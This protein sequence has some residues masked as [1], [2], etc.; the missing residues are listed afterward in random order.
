[1]GD[2]HLHAQLPVQLVLK[3]GTGHVW[4][5]LTGGIQPLKDWVMDFMHVSVPAILQGGFPRARKCW[6]QR[7]AVERLGS[8]PAL[9]AASCQGCPACMRTI[10]CTLA[11]WRCA[12][13]IACS[14]SHLGVLLASSVAGTGVLV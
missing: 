8:I 11:A 10:I 9:L 5:G 6:N 7:Y 2:T 3:M 1:M 12:S 14:C 13:P 4:G